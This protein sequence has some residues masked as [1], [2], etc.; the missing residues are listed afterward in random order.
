[1]SSATRTNPLGQPIGPELPGWSPRAVPSRTPMQG[2]FCTLEPLQGRHAPALFEAHALDRENRNWTYLPYGPF[3]SAEEYRAWVEKSAALTDP[4]FFAVLDRDGRPVG[5]ASFL[6][7][8]PANGVIEI[9]HLGFSPLMQ[10]TPIATEAIFLLL[11]RIFDEL[12]YRRC[13][14]KCDSLNAPSRAAALRFGFT[15]EGL[16]RQAVV[17]KGRS[18][19]TAWYS[20]ID[21][22]WPALRRGYEAWLAPANFDADGQQKEPLHKLIA[23][24]R[25]K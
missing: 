15:Y 24:A 13:E 9:G 2:R 12:G 4:L 10:R 25:G 18:R 16:F 20:I 11:R 19:D 23:G 6:R 1:M 22:E 17:V 8:D 5:V 7:I 14:W 3:A 21:P